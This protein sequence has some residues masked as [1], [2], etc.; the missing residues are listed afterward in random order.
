MS[1]EK[2]LKHTYKDNKI[3]IIMI[4]I[5]IIIT[6]IKVITRHSTKEISNDN[7][8]VVCVLKPQM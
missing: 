3:M 4:I 2:R 6:I 7:Y 1:S 8:L 5:I